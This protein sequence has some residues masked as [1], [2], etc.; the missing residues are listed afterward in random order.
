MIRDGCILVVD[1]DEPGRYAKAHVLRRG[2]YEVCEADTGMNALAV[3][4]DGELPAIVVLDVK[5]PDIDGIEVCRRLKAA[6]PGV[7]VLQTSAARVEGHDRVAGLVGGADSYMIEPMEPEEL[8]ATV[9]ALMRLHRA[10]AELR[11]SNETLE[12]SVIARTRELADL[13][14]KLIKESEQRSSVERALMHTQKLDAIGQLTGGIAHDFNNLL[15]VVLGN[16]ELLERS[17]SKPKPP[18]TQRLLQLV[19][20]ALQASRD[21]ESLT[22]QLLSFA[23]RNPARYE[24]VDVNRSIEE[25]VPLLRRAAGE[26]VT[27]EFALGPRLWPSHLDGSQLEAAILN[28]TVNAR[29]AMPAGGTLRIETANFVHAAD[30]KGDVLVPSDLAPGD[31]VRICVS[32]TGAGMEPDIQA[33]VFEPFFTTKDIGKGSGLGLSQVYGFAHQAGGAI[34]LDSAPGKGT[35]IAV[36]LPRSQETPATVAAKPQPEDDMPRGSETVLVVDDNFLVRGFVADTMTSLGYHVLEARDGPDALA[37]LDGQEQVNLL[38]TDIVMPNGMN[39]IELAREA[40]RRQPGLKVLVTSGY[41]QAELATAHG[42][43]PLSYLA[44]PYRAADLARRVRET[45]D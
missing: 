10:E 41:S 6:H 34:A 1:D 11:R 35:R 29:D 21:C 23:R 16:L 43:T 2:G 15:T 7:M 39:G 18:A 37:I 4:A 30:G 42:T 25:F 26:P 36:Y 17:L 8:L 14:T 3:A 19:H 22:R 5:L 31:Y 40:Q 20:G 9:G 32:D 33:H 28:L 24:I 38:F 44:K 12:Q 45:L 27:I 13:N